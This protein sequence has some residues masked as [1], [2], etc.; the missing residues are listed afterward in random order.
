[1]KERKKTKKFKQK[2]LV[3]QINIVELELE[4]ELETESGATNSTNIWKEF[5]KAYP[6]KQ[7]PVPSGVKN[8]QGKVVTNSNE[9]KDVTLKHFSHRMTKRPTHKDVEEIA[10]IKEST[11]PMIIKLASENKST[12]LTMDELELV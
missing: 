9:K 5:R 12:E 10:K 8:I 2:I 7:R 1:M 6:K 4:L 3:F 11:F